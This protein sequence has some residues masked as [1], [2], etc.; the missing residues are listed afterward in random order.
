MNAHVTF[1]NELTIC[2]VAEITGTIQAAF[3]EAKELSLDLSTVERID[4]AALQV[5]LA[6]HKEGEALGIPVTFL[7]SEPVRA[8]AA[9]VGV[10]L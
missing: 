8:Y 10:T 7:A 6:A 2:S 4:A 9:S 3:G 5:I 1:G